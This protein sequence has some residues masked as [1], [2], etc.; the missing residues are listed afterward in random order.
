[1]LGYF[2]RK[3]FPQ[4][5]LLATLVSIVFL[6]LGTFTNLHANTAIT[7]LPEAP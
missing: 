3:I 5:L 7:Q 6:G 4:F 1:M 2:V